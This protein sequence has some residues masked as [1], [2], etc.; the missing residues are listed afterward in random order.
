M[1]FRVYDNGQLVK[2]SG[3]L[4]TIINNNNNKE[5]IITNVYFI[6]YCTF[7]VT[8]LERT[9]RVNQ[10]KT[11]VIYCYNIYKLLKPETNF[12]WRLYTEIDRIQWIDQW[13]YIWS[14]P[15]STIQLMMIVLLSLRFLF[16][17]ILFFLV[18]CPCGKSWFT[19][20][21]D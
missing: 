13:I 6:W 5:K 16:Y 18:R 3:T 21:Y 14:V 19:L 8:H 7:S 12:I 11:L 20:V 17:F 2:R 10:R 15:F 4:T 1:S 9:G